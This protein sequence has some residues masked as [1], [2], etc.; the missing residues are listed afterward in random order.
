MITFGILSGFGLWSTSIGALFGA[1]GAALAV[2]LVA[3][4]QGGLTRDDRISSRRPGRRRSS[5]GALSVTD[6]G[7]TRTPGNRVG[8]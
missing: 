7:S 4:A 1:L 3:M 8:P 6:S 5:Q 2:Y